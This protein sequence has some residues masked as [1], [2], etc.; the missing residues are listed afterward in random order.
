MCYLVNP[1]TLTL[2]LALVVGLVWETGGG[3]LFLLAVL[4]MALAQVRPAIAQHRRG[5]GRNFRVAKPEK[6]GY[7]T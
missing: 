5:R 2:L 3:M 1:I 6:S 4:G 7:N